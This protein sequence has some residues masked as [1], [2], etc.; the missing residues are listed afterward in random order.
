MTKTTTV[1]NTYVV[2]LW[3]PQNINYSRIY[4]LVL[5]GGNVRAKD[6]CKLIHMSLFAFIYFIIKVL[7]W[8]L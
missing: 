2:V 6:Y 4:I 3:L 7:N 8:G 1:T 5:K